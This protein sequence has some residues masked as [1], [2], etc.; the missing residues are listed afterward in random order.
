MKTTCYGYRMPLCRS[1]L[2]R[3]LLAVAAAILLAGSGSR[4]GEPATTTETAEYQENWQ[5]AGAGP[6]RL[7]QQLRSH[8]IRLAKEGQ[9]IGEVLAWSPAAKELRP[10]AKASVNLLQSGRIAHRV[11]LDKPG[12]FTID[13][14]AP[15]V[16]S[17]VVAGPDGFLAC[18]TQLVGGASAGLGDARRFSAVIQPVFFQ[19]EQA[20]MDI[21]S[22]AVPPPSFPALKQLVTS[23]VPQEA[24]TLVNLV[25]PPTAEIPPG[26]LL[27]DA[28]R[29][30]PGAAAARPKATAE[31]SAY[32]AST[33]RQH[34]VH[35]LPDG[36]LL[37]RGRR[38]HRESGRPLRIHRTTVFMIRDKEVVA[39]SAID[40]LGVFTFKGLSP[41]MHSLVA[42][43]PE[44]F[45]A[46]AVSVEAALE[47]RVGN[48]KPVGGGRRFHLVAEQQIPDLSLDL[49]LLDPE[50]LPP[51]W[52]ILARDMGWMPPGGMPGGPAGVF[53][54]GLAG[55]SNPGT[56]PPGIGNV[57]GGVAGGGMDA[58][59]GA[60]GAVGGLGGG[61]IG[62]VGDDLPA[63]PF[64]P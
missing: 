9:L 7:G 37:G 50:N 4:A 5:Q 8:R 1:V 12:Q 30:E 54:N 28:A 11:M 48:S 60:G 64:R 49:G 22:L 46:F 39:A 53:P 15:G 18:S 13:G 41:G 56:M 29:D 36:R 35:L 51:L 32:P 63:T 2:G 47:G 27:Y 33:I 21:E 24:A 59:L 16:Y 42:T 10:V 19:V 57:V 23:Y 14:V 3:F 6:E 61:G 43:G 17:L 58:A 25:E 38:L 44:G 20:R 40:E 52:D 31:E 55:Q 26:A 45:A 34:T 62:D